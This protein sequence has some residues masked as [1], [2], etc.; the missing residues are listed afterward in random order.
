MLLL[1]A[2][3]MTLRRAVLGIIMLDNWITKV[4]PES[5]GRSVGCVDGCVVGLVHS[6]LV[7]RGVSVDIYRQLLCYCTFVYRYLRR[8]GLGGGHSG[9]VLY[10]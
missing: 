6:A 10:Q 5:R 8:L 3:R 2:N 7:R 9:D 4:R 1:V